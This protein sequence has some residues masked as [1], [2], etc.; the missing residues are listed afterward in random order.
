[1]NDFMRIPDYPAKASG[2]PVKEVVEVVFDYA[3]PNLVNYVTRVRRMR[4][5][6]VLHEIPL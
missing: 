6:T 4:G 1:M 2:A 3:I 5:Q